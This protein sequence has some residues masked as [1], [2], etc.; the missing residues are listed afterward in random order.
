MRLAESSLLKSIWW[1]SWRPWWNKKKEKEREAKENKTDKEEEEEKAKQ[2]HPGSEGGLTG[3]HKYETWD[4][5][6]KRLGNIKDF[7]V[8]CLGHHKDKV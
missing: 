2:Q 7:H 4:K 5:G 1:W 3:V 6:D 8:K